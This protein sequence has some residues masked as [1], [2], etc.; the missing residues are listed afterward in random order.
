MRVSA[1]PRRQNGRYWARTSD[2]Q[3]VKTEQGSPLFAELRPERSVDWNQPASEH[4]SAHAHSLMPSPT[5]SDPQKHPPMTVG[6][7]PE[8]R[9]TGR[10][11]WTSGTLERR[12]TCIN[13]GIEA[14]VVSSPAPSRELL[15]ART[16]PVARRLTPTLKPTL[17]E[18]EPTSKNPPLLCS[19]AGGGLGAGALMVR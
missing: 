19:L 1:W 17:S 9:S 10:S 15:S 18:R 11:T 2:L 7:P 3:L 6:T 12:E 16:A 5:P 14:I 4:L 13:K 8:T